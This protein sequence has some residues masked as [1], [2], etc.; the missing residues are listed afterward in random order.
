VT[1]NISFE[2]EKCEEFEA[3][4]NGIKREIETN[5]IVYFLKFSFGF[6]FEAFVIYSVYGELIS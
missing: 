6:C 2:S 3:N 5:L 1:E 4:L